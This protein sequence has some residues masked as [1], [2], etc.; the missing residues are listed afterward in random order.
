[1]AGGR[2]TLY[3]GRSDVMDESKVAGLLY[4]CLILLLW[5]LIRMGK[6]GWLVLGWK[7][8]GWRD[9]ISKME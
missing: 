4:S 5:M 2:S 3:S 7:Q 8:W 6:L 9:V 1:M